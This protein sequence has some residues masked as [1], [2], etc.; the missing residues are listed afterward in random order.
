M[1]IAWDM[2]WAVQEITD[3]SASLS[4]DAGETIVETKA[5]AVL[6][7]LSIA[8]VPPC[9]VSLLVLDIVQGAGYR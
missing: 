9:S 2:I 5:F 3:S 4:D 6:P 7:C 8:F 1:E